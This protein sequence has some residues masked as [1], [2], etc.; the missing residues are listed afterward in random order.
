MKLAS[1]L[2]PEQVILDLKGDVCVE[3]ISNIVDHLI[4]K[5]LLAADSREE[6]M[7][8]L[9]EREQQI[10]TG[11]GSGVAIPHA[12]SDSVD[13]VVAA[14][15]RSKE[16]CDFESLDNAPVNFVILFVVPKKDYSL[17]LQTLAAIAKMFNNC[18]IRQQ[19]SAAETVEDVL[20]IFAS[21]PS[22]IH[23]EK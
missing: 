2:T 23:A 4:D 14:F 10:S 19:L 13:Q 16:G 3:A 15:A 17:H 11:I 5:K 21:R 1:L 9:E 22:R 8:A 20:D 6:I 7:E 12:F 18:A